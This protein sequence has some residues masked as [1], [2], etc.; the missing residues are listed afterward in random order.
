MIP[1][2]DHVG[3]GVGAIIVRGHK[4]L[5]LLRSEACRNNAGLWTIPGG[6]VETFE[7]LDDAVR[8]ETAEEVGLTVTSEKLIAVSDRIFEGQHWVSILYH[9]ET[10]DEPRNMEPEKH[11]KLEW[12]DLDHLPENITAPSR[13]AIEAYLK[14]HP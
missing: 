2:I 9:C 7:T 6:M 8:R 11:H 5:M 12:H 1:G 13:D 14:E 10:T 4:V 3:L